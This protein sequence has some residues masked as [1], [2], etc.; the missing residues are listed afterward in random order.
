MKTST[1]V[2]ALIDLA[3]KTSQETAEIIEDKTI[4]EAIL[5]AVEGVLIGTRDSIVEPLD[6][7]EKVIIMR[8]YAAGLT[9]NMELKDITLKII[10]DYADSFHKDEN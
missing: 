8:A 10:E 6:N 3:I 1:L 7:M 2:E 4:R 9:T 5:E